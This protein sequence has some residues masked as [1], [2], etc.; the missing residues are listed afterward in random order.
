MVRSRPKSVPIEQLLKL[1][2]RLSHMW[3]SFGQVWDGTGR[4][5]VCP[6]T[7]QSRFNSGQFSN[8]TGFDRIRSGHNFVK[9]ANFGSVGDNLRSGQVISKLILGEVDP[10]FGRIWT[11][12]VSL[13][14]VCP[15]LAIFESFYTKMLIFHFFKT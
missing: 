8:V 7:G 11:G 3:V 15:G 6:G 12:Q 1:A 9:W 4:T 14:T 5:Q 2:Q 13:E 10:G